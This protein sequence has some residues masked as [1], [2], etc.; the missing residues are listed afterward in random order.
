MEGVRNRN[1]NGHTLHSARALMTVRYLRH[2][3]FSALA[4]LILCAA[5]PKLPAIYAGAPASTPGAEE[6]TLSV[7]LGDKRLSSP[8]WSVGELVQTSAPGQSQVGE[9]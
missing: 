2:G 3:T 6:S 9:G 8:S 7:G 1:R 4:A 5:P